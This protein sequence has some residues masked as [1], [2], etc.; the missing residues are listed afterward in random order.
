MKLVS[1]NGANGAAATD[2]DKIKVASDGIRAGNKA[3]KNVA[4][5]EISAASTDAI[6]GSQLYAVAKG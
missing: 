3:V 4:A 6:N 1:A 5:G 2:A